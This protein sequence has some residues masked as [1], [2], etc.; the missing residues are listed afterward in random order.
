[1]KERLNY[2]FKAYQIKC[3]DDTY[4]WV[5]R[6]ADVPEVVGGG[7]T[8][9]EAYNEAMSNLEY[10]FETLKEEGKEIPAP[11]QDPEENDYSGK[12]V[13]RLSK[14]N[15]KK[16]AELSEQENISINALLNEIINEGI[17]KRI[18]A[19]ALKELI[20]DTEKEYALQNNLSL[21]LVKN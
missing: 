11:T 15:H 18:S 5:V 3:E 6:F 21:N 16:L 8:V 20:A 1:M 19:K 4:G 14:S 9:E 2:R 12:L 7:D 17:T 13:L 10:Y